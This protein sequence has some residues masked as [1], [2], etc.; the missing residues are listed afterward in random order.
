MSAAPQKGQSRR[1]WV[2]ILL[3]SVLGLAVTTGLL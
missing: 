3:A 2:S 1:Y